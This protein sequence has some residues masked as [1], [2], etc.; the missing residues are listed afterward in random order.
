M[1][2]I[3]LYI[4]GA[5]VLITL[6]NWVVRFFVLSSVRKESPKSIE[7]HIEIEAN[8]L[9]V[10]ESIKYKIIKN[11]LEKGQTPEDV[12]TLTGLEENEVKFVA[13]KINKSVRTILSNIKKDLADIKERMS[14]LKAEQK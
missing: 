4:I 3:Y 1:E 9:L 7:E 14:I 8:N 12:V 10:E 13:A 2:N 5:F 11:M 6:V